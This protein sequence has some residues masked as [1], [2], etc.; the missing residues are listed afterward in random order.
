MEINPQRFTWETAG[1]RTGY[2]IYDFIKRDDNEEFVRVNKDKY[3]LIG[4]CDGVLLSVRPRTNEFAALFDIL[5][6]DE[7]EDK[8]WIH[9]PNTFKKLF[10]ETK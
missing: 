5:D 9:F 2:H 1:L 6:E 7:L 3:K 4:T 8:V 10:E